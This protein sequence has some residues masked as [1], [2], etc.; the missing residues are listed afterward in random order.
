MGFC[1]CSLFGSTVSASV[2]GIIISIYGII[3]KSIFLE[4]ENIIKPNLT[5]FESNSTVGEGSKIITKIIESVL[6]LYYDKTVKSI[7]IVSLVIYVLW[8]I[9]SVAIIIG[10]QKRIVSALASWIMATLIVIST[11]VSLTIF[12]LYEAI[13]EI[14]TSGVKLESFWMVRKVLGNIIMAS[15]FDKGII[16]LAILISLIIYVCQRAKEISREKTQEANQ[17]NY[18]TIP[19]INQYG[20]H[21]FNTEPSAY[22]S[23]GIPSLSSMAPIDPNRKFS[24]I[25]PQYGS[26][27]AIPPPY[28][29]EKVN[30]S[31]YMRAKAIS[32]HSSHGYSHRDDG[33]HHFQTHG[34][35]LPEPEVDYDI[36]RYNG[37]QQRGYNLY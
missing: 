4:L 19:H 14:Q 28:E 18:P 3:W 7:V 23:R 25:N 35:R 2:I 12:F 29:Q 27:K 8:F 31:Q 1:G 21:G 5:I 30:S 24:Y 34:E 37:H 26:V 20:N 22:H 17:T 6:F 11:D 32:Q 9:A 13:K 16:V 33:F 36:D 15:L 10:N